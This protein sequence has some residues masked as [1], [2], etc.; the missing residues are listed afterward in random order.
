ML[1][2]IFV[3]VLFLI[4]LAVMPI[5]TFSEAK[6]MNK[7]VNVGNWIIKPT[8]SNSKSIRFNFKTLGL[9]IGVF[10][11]VFVTLNLFNLI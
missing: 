1:S 8:F 4:A 9:L 6:K 2:Q 11:I 5:L 10:V 7:E 3:L